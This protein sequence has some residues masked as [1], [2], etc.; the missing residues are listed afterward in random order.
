MSVI[1]CR[2]ACVARVWF[3]VFPRGK[4][5][6]HALHTGTCRRAYTRGIKQSL[7]Y[8]NKYVTRAI[9]D[10]KLV[11]L[12]ELLHACVFDMCLFCACEMSSCTVVSLRNEEEPALTL[13]CDSSFALS[14]T[15]PYQ[16]SCQSTALLLTAAKN[17]FVSAVRWSFVFCFFALKQ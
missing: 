16:R 13:G 4:Y 11:L 14:V 1:L 8:R 17:S 15:W 6:L 2:Q 3:G 7:M 9:A 12:G 5:G 10:V